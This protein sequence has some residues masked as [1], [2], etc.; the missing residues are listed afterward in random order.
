MKKTILR[1]TTLLLAST[2]LVTSISAATVV[3]PYNGH[4]GSW[5]WGHD[6]RVIYTYSE[7]ASTYYSHSASVDGTMSGIKGPGTVAHAEK[8]GGTSYYWWIV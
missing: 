2:A 3:N 1:F 6:W 4:R 5:H 7:T 8:I